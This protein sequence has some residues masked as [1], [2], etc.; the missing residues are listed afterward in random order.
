[1][2]LFTLLYGL[3]AALKSAPKWDTDRARECPGAG[4]HLTT[5]AMTSKLENEAVLDSGPTPAPRR[6]YRAPTLKRLGS[7]RELT[8]G[9]S[10]GSGE[11][12]TGM[13]PLAKM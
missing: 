9:N 3:S 10:P 13:L 1:M 12:G 2:A 7:V 8:L 6:M 5:C 4:P 11:A